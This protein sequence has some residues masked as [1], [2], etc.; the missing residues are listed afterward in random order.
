MCSL[1]TLPLVLISG[2][3]CSTQGRHKQ[4]VHIHLECFLDL[5]IQSDLKNKSKLVN[6]LAGNSNVIDFT[7]YMKTASGKLPW[8]RKVS[9][10][11]ARFNTSVHCTTKIWGKA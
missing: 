9:H 11:V 5:K 7:C 8:A 2:A 6:K 3:C 4:V 1:Q 10:R